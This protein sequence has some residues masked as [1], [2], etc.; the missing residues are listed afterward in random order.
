M[1]FIA[2]GPVA[3]WVHDTVPVNKKAH[4]THVV[5]MVLKAPGSFYFTMSVAVLL[6]L[7]HSRHIEAAASLLLSGVAGGAAYLIVKWL[8]GRHRPVI[9]IAPWKLHPFPQG[10]RGI[11]RESALS[12]PSGHASLAFSSATCLA[13]LLPRWAPVFFL[14][15]IVTG[16]ERVIENAHYV[17]DVVAGAG[18]G[19][20]L[21][22][23]VTRALVLKRADTGGIPTVPAK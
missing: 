16:T 18:L 20:L 11:W 15:A 9:E 2:D 6:G 3:N 23:L 21:G 17:S 19:I 1:A 10:F 13:M 5:L 12:F 4:G 7:F 8:V 22:W 14:I